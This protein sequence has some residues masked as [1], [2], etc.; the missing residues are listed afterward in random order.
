MRIICFVSEFR[1]MSA[2]L[3][4]IQTLYG[5]LLSLLYYLL[6]FFYLF[7]IIYFF[8]LFIAKLNKM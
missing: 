3:A 8:L 1:I 7:I 5:L 4:V 6:F 2:G